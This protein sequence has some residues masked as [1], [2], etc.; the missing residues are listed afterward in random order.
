VCT[1]LDL[2]AAERGSAPGADRAAQAIQVPVY[3]S[4][5]DRQL[6]RVMKVVREALTSRLQAAPP[7]PS[8]AARL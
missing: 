7:A 6:R 5:T 1:Q 4:L 8:Q 3:A 2:F